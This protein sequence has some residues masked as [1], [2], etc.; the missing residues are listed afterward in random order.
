ML[1]TVGRTPGSWILAHGS[2]AVHALKGPRGLAAHLCPPQ[3]W[4]N[5]GTPQA[6]VCKRLRTGRKPNVSLSSASHRDFWAVGADT[7]ELDPGSSAASIPPRRS[8]GAQPVQPPSHLQNQPQLCHSL[9]SE[10]APGPGAGVCRAQRPAR[11]LA[12]LHKHALLAPHNGRRPRPATA[13]VPCRASRHR[14]GGAP[15]PSGKREVMGTGRG[16]SGG[17]GSPTHQ[18]P[19]LHP[20]GRRRLP[21]PRRWVSAGDAQGAGSFVGAV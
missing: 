16:R 13:S 14:P 19:W 8:R 3:R 12:W 5:R 2:N 4:G 9:G 20:R 10:A 15:R 1:G 18:M 21:A 11:L 17:C 7:R 6:G